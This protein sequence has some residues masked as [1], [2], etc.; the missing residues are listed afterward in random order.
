[1]DAHAAASLLDFVEQARPR[2]RGFDGDAT[3]A[4]L[5]DR[6]D[7]FDDA[8]EWFLERDRPND[9]LRMASAL[10]PF[11]MA[12]KRMDDGSAWLARILA[13]GGGDDARRARGLFDAGYLAFWQ[14]NHEQSSRLYGDAL[15]LATAIDEPTVTAIV[16][17]GLARIALKTDVEE[18]RRLCREALEVTQGTDDREGR[19]H[20]THVLGVAAQMAGDFEE[21]RRYMSERLALAREE[22]N[23]AT[24]S[25]E[26]TNLSM[27][28]RQLGN[29]DA[30]EELS[31][32]ALG[33]AVRRGD[34]LAIPWMLNGLAA[35]TA[36][37]GAHERGAMLLGAADALLESAGGEWPPDELAQHEQT[38]GVLTEA[39]GEAELASVRAAGQ[40]MNEEDA[41]AFALA[42]PD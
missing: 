16:L 24:M 31:R 6:Y 10:T 34:G 3:L 35:V 12:T 8:L 2:L 25:I 28:E 5:Q 20:A 13:A 33:L 4:Q 40:S 21:A 7:D 22:G 32:E 37:K 42:A 30:A 29:L 17:T 14:G 23:V 27:V 26:A 38:V 15:T 19:S 36:A 41:V 39:M 11:W 9:A 18:A 1:M